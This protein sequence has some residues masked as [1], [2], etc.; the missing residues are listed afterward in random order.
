MPIPLVIFLTACWLLFLQGEF[1]Q[2][3]AAEFWKSLSLDGRAEAHDAS[4]P[5]VSGTLYENVFHPPAPVGNERISVEWAS[6]YEPLAS[7]FPL[8]AHLLER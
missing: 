8:R 2:E 1:A 7:G 3:N 4:A 6:V 5:S